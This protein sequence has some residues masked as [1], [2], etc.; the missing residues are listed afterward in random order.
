MT[1]INCEGPQLD[2][3]AVLAFLDLYE[4]ELASTDVLVV[5]GSIPP[6]VSP[7]IYATMIQ[8]AK[9]SGIP[10]VLDASGALLEEGI[11]AGPTILKPNK[12][13]LE[14]LIG[15]PVKTLD[16]S[17]DACQKLLNCG[18]S[19]ICLSMGREGALLVQDCGVWFSEG[20]DIRVRSFQGAGDS[21]VA[22]LCMALQSHLSGDEM[23]RSGVAAAHGSLIREGTLLCTRA[24]YDYFLPLIPVHRL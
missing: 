15:H 1:E 3:D 10:T 9:A 23:L 16:E 4:K 21:M 6:G 24:S 17:I 5:T 14:T 2:P 8:R 11:A 18:I 22:G 13:E 20:L 7:K 19:I 12:L